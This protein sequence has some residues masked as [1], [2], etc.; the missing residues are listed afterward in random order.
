LTRPT[1]KVVLD[2]SCTRKLNDS[3]QISKN[4]PSPATQ[5]IRRRFL[6]ASPA[7]LIFYQ[8]RA[9]LSTLCFHLFSRAAGSRPE[10]RSP[11]RP[12]SF[13]SSAIAA[14]LVYHSQI[15]PPVKTLNSFIFNISK[16]RKI[17]ALN[18]RNP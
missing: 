7:S 12:P 9:A 16:A 13:P 8:T 1:Q 4:D 18:E 5:K 6:L 17:N 3:I 15:L 2:E 10:G 14:R 11:L